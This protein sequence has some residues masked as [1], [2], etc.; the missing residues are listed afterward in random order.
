MK[1]SN[2]AFNAQGLRLI[3]V[4]V[5]VRPVNICVAAVGCSG[6]RKDRMK[7]SLPA[8]VGCSGK[9]K[10]RM[11]LSLPPKLIVF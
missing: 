3:I 2:S 1:C 10:D 5:Q 8:A 6:K 7:L 4:V 11:K 9:R